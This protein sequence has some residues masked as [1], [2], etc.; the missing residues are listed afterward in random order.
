MS[1]RQHTTLSSWRLMTFCHHHSLRWYWHPQYPS[2]FDSQGTSQVPQLPPLIS[3]AHTAVST[4]QPP[5]QPTHIPSWADDVATA[6]QSVHSTP[7]TVVPNWAYSGRILGARPRSKPLVYPPPVMPTPLTQR[8]PV[9]S[10]RYVPA[11]P[12]LRPQQ[13]FPQPPPYDR[14]TS[15]DNYPCTDPSPRSRPRTTAHEIFPV[16]S[17]PIQASQSPV[18]HTV[19][20]PQGLQ[21]SSSRGRPNPFAP[22]HG[23][24]H[25]SQGPNF[26]FHEFTNPLG[27]NTIQGIHVPERISYTSNP[28]QHTLKPT[29][30][31]CSLGQLENEYVQE[32]RD[33]DLPLECLLFPINSCFTERFWHLSKYFFALADR[34]ND[35][36]NTSF[37]RDTAPFRIYAKYDPFYLQFGFLHPTQIEDVNNTTHKVNRLKML[38]TMHNY[39]FVQR[40]FQHTNPII[41]MN[42]R[43]QYA[44]TKLTS[45]Y[46]MNYSYIIQPNYCEGTLRNYDPIKN[47]FIFSPLYA[48]TNRPILVPIEYLQCVE[49]G[50][51][52]LTYGHTFNFL[53]RDWMADRLENRQPSQEELQ[54]FNRLL[55][56]QQHCNTD[57]YPRALAACLARDPEFLAFFR[58][59]D[60]RVPDV[61]F[62]YRT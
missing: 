32:R 22:T 24:P 15:T 30:S 2:Q 50:A 51:T 40:P 44:N 23:I 17:S 16:H 39:L 62:E 25:R 26:R 35:Y 33:K 27:I 6:E 52:K 55:A 31:S 1:I 13:S 3:T 36:H 57:L 56:L 42:S 10:P 45:P 9:P 5:I 38:H 37:T 34:Q 41:H 53:Y 46:Y 54:M 4:T 7:E 20:P 60:N 47:Y 29:A 12:P 11:V 19:S 14:P 58:D 8:P 61:E 49:G 21:L 18:H 59:P 28:P 43:L 48:K